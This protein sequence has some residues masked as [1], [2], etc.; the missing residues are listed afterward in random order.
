MNLRKIFSNAF[1]LFN[2]HNKH[3]INLGFD[4]EVGENFLNGIMFCIEYMLVFLTHYDLGRFVL[5]LL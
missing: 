3:P 4:V 5:D 1:L 2:Y